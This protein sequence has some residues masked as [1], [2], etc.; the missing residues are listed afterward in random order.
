MIFDCLV[1]RDVLLHVVEHFSDNKVY[2]S[3]STNGRVNYGLVDFSGPVL[4]DEMT[5]SLS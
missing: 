5:M 4:R 1:E 3:V 2:V